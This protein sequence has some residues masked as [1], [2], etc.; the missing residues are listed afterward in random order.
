MQQ[1]IPP[2]E[3]VWLSLADLIHHGVP[4]RQGRMLP[5]DLHSGTYDLRDRNPGKGGQLIGSELALDTTS[6]HQVQPNSPFCCYSG[7]P[8]FYPSIE[9]VILFQYYPLA[10]EAFDLC[11]QNQVDVSSDCFDWWSDDPS[12]AQG[13]WPT[14]SRSLRM[15]GVSLLLAHPPQRVRPSQ[16]S[17]PYRV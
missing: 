5:A 7:N 11:T 10:V 13:G 12:I 6:G 15:S 3:Q 4:D 9:E 14:H 17:V 2:G 1:T 16:T 8:S